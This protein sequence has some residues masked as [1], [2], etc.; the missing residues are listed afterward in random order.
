[1]P[2]H[3]RQYLFNVKLLS[4]LDDS[5]GLLDANLAIVALILFEELLVAAIAVAEAEELLEQRVNETCN[6][7]STCYA[8]KGDGDD[9][10]IVGGFFLLEEKHDT[11]LLY[12]ISFL[13]KNS[14]PQF[15]KKA[16]VF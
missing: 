15:Q 10:T 12:Q 4:V 9:L 7:T 16:S 14:I 8:S 3:T 13:C 2:S 1:V 5:L 6:G 11:D